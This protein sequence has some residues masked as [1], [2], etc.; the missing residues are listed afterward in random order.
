MG[1]GL[2]GMKIKIKANKL[3][4]KP[5]KLAI[6]LGKTSTTKKGQ[7]G[8]ISEINAPHQNFGPLI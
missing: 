3:P 1:L 7:T 5:L 6:Y 2:C 4:I 8:D